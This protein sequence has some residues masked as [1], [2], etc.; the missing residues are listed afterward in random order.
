M[1]F[2]DRPHPYASFISCHW[3]HSLQTESLNARGCR[4]CCSCGRVER[5]SCPLGDLNDSVLH[6]MQ[7][8]MILILEST[9]LFAKRPFPY[10][11][12]HALH[13]MEYLNGN[14]CV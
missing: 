9:T 10:G 14:F 5:G 7:R 12:Y 13:A 11:P 4:S 3:G 1:P 2:L 6:G 8:L